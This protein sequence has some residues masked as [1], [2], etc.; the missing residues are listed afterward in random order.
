MTRRSRPH[1]RTEAKAALLLGK[2]L[3]QQPE[4]RGEILVGEAGVRLRQNPDTTVGVDVAY[5]SAET[6]RLTPPNAFLVEG[7]PV[8]AVEILSRSDVWGDISDKVAS[9]LEAGTKV[10]WL[11]DPV[12]RTVIVYQKGV[13]PEL[14]NEKME[15]S[16][17]PHLPGFVVP[18]KAIF[19]P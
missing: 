18:V 17:D 7:A 8:L 16:A 19:E 1:S 11:V 3:E 14:F 15:I 4:P 10:V 5:I 6:A 2:W 9:Y 13:P 12:F